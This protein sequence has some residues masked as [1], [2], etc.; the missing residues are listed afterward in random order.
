MCCP[1]PLACSSSALGQDRNRRPR[2]RIRSTPTQDGL[3]EIALSVTDVRLVSKYT[4]TAREICGARRRH[5][6]EGEKAVATTN[7][8]QIQKARR[9]PLLPSVGTED[10]DRSNV[11]VG[12]LDAPHKV[13]LPDSGFGLSFARQTSGCWWHAGGKR[14]RHSWASLLLESRGQTP[15]CFTILLKCPKHR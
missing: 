15:W 3:T 1:N 9:L 14:L 7:P 5:A 13:R 2:Q 11:F 6:W 4:R 10:Q 12:A 8:C